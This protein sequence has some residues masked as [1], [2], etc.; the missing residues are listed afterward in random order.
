[1]SSQYAGAAHSDDVVG[2]EV[3]AVERRC[4]YFGRPIAV[5]DDRVER[6]A[7]RHSVVVGSSQSGLEIIERGGPVVGVTGMRSFKEIHRPV[8]THPSGDRYVAALKCSIR[9]SGR[10]VQSVRTYR[11]FR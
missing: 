4:S 11:R 6:R 8:I 7:T 10:P 1:M 2:V 3:V 5:S 9:V